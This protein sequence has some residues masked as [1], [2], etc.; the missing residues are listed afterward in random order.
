[1]EDSKAL[2]AAAQA[3]TGLSDFGDDG[4]QEGLERLVRALNTEARLNAAGDHA[5][6]D[7]ILLHLRQRLMVEDWY[8]RFPQIEDERIRSPS[9]ASACRGRDRRP[10]RSCSPVTRKSAICG[11]GKARSPVRHPPP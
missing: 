4:F 6:R 9:S 3:E 11:S 10:C 2:M 8:R 7:R 1:M 5:L